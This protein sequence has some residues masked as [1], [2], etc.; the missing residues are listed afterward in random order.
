MMVFFTTIGLGASF[1]LFKIG[2]KVLILYFVCCAFLAICQNFI[3]IS[4]A[5][6]LHI[7]PLLGLTAG[8]MSMEGGHGN[9]AAYGKTL[10]E[11]FNID[12]A[13]TAALAAATLGLVFGGLVGGPLVKALI[14]RYNL[15][16]ENSDD[17]FKDYSKV[18]S[19]E[20]LHRKY[21]PTQVFFIQLTIIALCMSVGTWIGDQFSNLTGQSLP[22][23]VG[24]MFVAVA[25]RNVSEYA[26]IQLIDLKLN[27]QIGD[28]ALGLFLSLALMSIQLTQVYSLALPLSLLF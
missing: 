28:V 7:K 20:V 14:K 2:G 15:K 10:E 12:S 8:S 5:K 1:K 27:D 9:A 16:P 21:Q 3:G 4:L 6:V 11:S 13:I 24:S 23:Y 18:E 19:N 22:M 26:N 17:S 25:I